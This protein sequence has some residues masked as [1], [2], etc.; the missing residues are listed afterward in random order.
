M[1]FYKKKYTLLI[2]GILYCPVNSAE[3]YN[4]E[5]NICV[6]RENYFVALKSI[7]LKENDL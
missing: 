7:N 4:Y 1:S 2:K 5:N 6:M 3:F